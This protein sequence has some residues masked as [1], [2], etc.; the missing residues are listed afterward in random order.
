MNHRMNFFLNMKGTLIF[1]AF[2]VVLSVA[3]AS[4]AVADSNAVPQSVRSVFNQPANPQEGCDPFFPNSNRPYESL[5]PVVSAAGDLSMLVMQG[6]SGAPGHR[7]VIINNVTFGV[8]DDS[9][10]HTPQGSVHVQC[11]EINS[12]SAVI[13]VGGQRHT[14]HYDDKP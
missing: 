5:T 12:D 7:L 8:G 9:E 13:E 2:A 3:S 6:I 11:V 4:G 14:L 10:V 1:A